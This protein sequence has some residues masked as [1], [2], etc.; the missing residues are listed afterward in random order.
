M[1]TRSVWLE[2]LS[3]QSP[4]HMEKHHPKWIFENPTLRVCVSVCLCALYTL[5][6]LHKQLAGLHHV[7]NKRFGR[8]QPEGVVR[9]SY[10]STVRTIQ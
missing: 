5:C 4:E 10:K 3:R 2:T 7:H 9:A 6:A 1:Y 8:G